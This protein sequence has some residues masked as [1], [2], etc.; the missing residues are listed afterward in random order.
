MSNTIEQLEYIFG[1]FSD[2]T[3]TDTLKVYL[4]TLHS[5]KSKFVDTDGVLQFYIRDLKEIVHN[6]NFLSSD[7]WEQACAITKRT[8]LSGY[9]TWGDYCT[10]NTLLNSET[11]DIVELDD[12]VN[13]VANRIKFIYLVNTIETLLKTRFIGSGNISVACIPDNRF[14]SQIRHSS[15]DYQ[16]NAW[17]KAKFTYTIAS[18]QESCKIY[19]EP[20]YVKGKILNVVRPASISKDGKVIIGYIELDPSIITADDIYE[21]SNTI[22]IEVFISAEEYAR[23]STDPTLGLL[24]SLNA[25]LTHPRFRF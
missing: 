21:C 5:L 8:I 23:V 11:F 10:I 16:H 4:T 7:E 20:I 3:T 22:P 17:L 18:L 14:G 1:N 9:F 6:T 25:F 13:T 19:R 24:F 12:E 2:T 15:R